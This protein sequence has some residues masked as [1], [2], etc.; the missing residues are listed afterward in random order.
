MSACHSSLCTQGNGEDQLFITPS[1]SLDIYRPLA[2][3]ALQAQTALAQVLPLLALIIHI[4]AM[5]L[6][7]QQGLPHL[8]GQAPT[9]QCCP[10]VS[11]PW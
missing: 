6:V 9:N 3:H 2:K 11:G 10:C 4:T 1:L 5:I 7:S 8:L